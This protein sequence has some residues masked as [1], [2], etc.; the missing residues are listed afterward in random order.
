[1]V[2]E[3]RWKF[4]KLFVSIVQSHEDGVEKPIKAGAMTEKAQDG[5]KDGVPKRPDIFNKFP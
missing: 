1:M 3:Y 5:W 4:W 2:P